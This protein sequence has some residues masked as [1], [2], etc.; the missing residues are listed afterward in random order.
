MSLLF[1]LKFRD[2][3]FFWTNAIDLLFKLL[4]FFVQKI[5]IIG[6]R[7]NV[8]DDEWFLIDFMMR[9]VKSLVLYKGKKLNLKLLPHF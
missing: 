6:D 8:L 9:L 5:R 1:R 3:L 2:L 7:L 4:L